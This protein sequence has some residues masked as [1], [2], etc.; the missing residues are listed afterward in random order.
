M[1]TALY[2]ASDSSGCKGFDIV[3]GSLHLMERK[4]PL[5]MAPGW[6]RSAFL[7][8]RSRSARRSE[9]S[10]FVPPHPRYSP[11]AARSHDRAHVRHVA[12]PC[13]G[14]VE[15]LPLGHVALALPVLDLLLQGVPL[16]LDVLQL[17]LGSRLLVVQLAEHILGSHLVLV[18]QLMN[19]V[20]QPVQLVSDGLE[21]CLRGALLATATQWLG[22]CWRG[23]AMLHGAGTRRSL[24]LSSIEA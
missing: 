19:L 7:K 12:M 14:G 21:V 15:H 11:V 5:E 3:S 1:T 8:F 6:L 20:V 24:A 4:P 2:R 18:V 10:P 23:M 22:P 13:L 9:H 16:D 17:G